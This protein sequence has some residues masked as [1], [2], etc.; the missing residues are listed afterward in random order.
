MKAIDNFK[1]KDGEVESISGI[2][3]TKDMEQ[4]MLSPEYCLKV[5]EMQGEMNAGKY[6]IRIRTQEGSYVGTIYLK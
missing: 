4:I 5:E 2:I 3:I 1:D 6:C